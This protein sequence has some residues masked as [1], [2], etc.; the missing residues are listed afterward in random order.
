MVAAELKE[1][2]ADHLFHWGLRPFLSDRDY[3]RWQREHLS[4]ADLHQ[5]R[6][7][8]ETRHRNPR[9]GEADLAFY[10]YAAQAHI[11]PTL[12]SQRFDYYLTVGA[13]VTE[14]IDRAQRILDLGC[15]LGILTTFY[16][17]QAPH[18]T[19]VGVD[20][21]PGSLDVA[22]RQ[23]A[24]LGLVHC[25]FA[26][27][28]LN[29]EPLPGTYD[30]I[31]ASQSL[32][33]S[34]SDP[35]LPSESWR[36]HARPSDE[37]AQR[38]FERRTGVGVRVDRIHAALAPD[39]RIV[40][41]EKTRHLG[42]RIGF[43]RALAA[44]GLCLIEPALPLRYQSVEEVTDDGPLYV[45]SP[46][47]GH[48]DAQPWDETPERSADEAVYSQSGPA[49]EYVWQRLIGRSRER[50]VSFKPPGMASGEL[51]WGRA[52]VFDYLYA[53]RH[54]GFRGLQVAPACPDGIRLSRLA[55]SLADAGQ[56]GA[57]IVEL[58]REAFG[59]A[60]SPPEP[61][62]APLY[63]NHRAAA[64]AVYLALPARTVRQAHDQVLP[65]GRQL[66]IE[67]GTSGNFFYLYCANTYDQRQLVVFEPER[68]HLLEQ[69][70]RDL[71]GTTP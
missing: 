4:P 11:Y 58:L 55:E 69:Y 33:Q 23:A 48:P 52:G 32:L 56:D 17:R 22:R 64:Q 40:L 66:H 24:K 34:E 28:D 5:L 44:R 45:L 19:V 63:E 68:A 59:A 62:G 31:I 54:N 14:R 61:A 51:E 29:H 49:A 57:R 36:T 13:A 43:Q 35:G 20:R 6:L 71:S 18:A 3:D 50:T 21:S 26:R 42:R 70:Y 41:C 30:L 47:A 37:A 25:S 9:N 7:L 39:G 10:E 67:L 8:A 65:D 38:D 16:A 12:Y 2:L 27:L 46:Q 1:A 53:S 15:G 60:A